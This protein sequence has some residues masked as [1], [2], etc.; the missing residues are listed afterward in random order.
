[1]GVYNTCGDIYNTDLTMNDLCNVPHYKG[2]EPYGNYNALGQ[3]EGYFW[4]YGET[5]RLNFSIDG[6]VTTDSKDAL[7]NSIYVSASDYLQGKVAQVK[8]YNFRYEELYVKT[9]PASENVV[10]EL[11]AETSSKFIKGTYYLTLY[12]IGDDSMTYIPLI[13]DK[14]CVITVR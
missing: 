5:I 2:K 1:M 14:D 7:G 8:I 12:I 9:L 3:L 11:D 10:I 4:Y 6:E 13:K